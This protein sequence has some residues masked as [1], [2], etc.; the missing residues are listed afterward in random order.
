VKK[1]ILGLMAASALAIAAPALA[2]E[3]PD[4]ENDGEQW[5]TSYDQYQQQFQHIREGI[6]HGLGDGSYTRYQASRFYSELRTLERQSQAYQYNDGELNPGE[7]RWIQAR[8]TRLH[9]IMHQVHDRGHETQEG[10]G[11]NNGQGYS[12]GQS[13][14]GQSYNNGS[15]TDPYNR[16][17]YRYY[18][19]VRR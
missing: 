17:Q 2:H 19:G 9:D 11:Y 4:Q 13:Y 12:N 18:N 10:Y 14:Y 3:H 8:L 15:S 16:Y 6:Q 5:S 7:G 1:L